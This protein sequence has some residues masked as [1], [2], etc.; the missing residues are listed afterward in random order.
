MELAFKLAVITKE[1]QRV[2]DL[3][4]PYIRTK[5]NEDID[6]SIKKQKNFISGV[7][8]GEFDDEYED[9]EDGDD[10][11]VLFIKDKNGEKEFVWNAKIKEI[12]WKDIVE[13]EN[14]KLEEREVD[15][16]KHRLY[17]EN[18]YYLT[19][20]IITPDGIWHGMIPKSIITVGFKD[21]E[22]HKEYLSNY[23]K[24]YIKPY[25]EDGCITILT[26]NI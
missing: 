9:E 16:E 26:C 12:N 6:V 19:D 4:K 3:I 2:E 17:L 21:K 20:S 8:F 13:F 5:Y 7:K 11:Y 23:Y 1:G 24:K 10:N 22:T 14:E 18:K 25:E 15:M